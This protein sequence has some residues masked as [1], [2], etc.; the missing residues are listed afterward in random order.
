MPILVPNSQ[1]KIRKPGTKVMED[2]LEC[3]D[4]SF[5]N[6]VERCL[7]WDP[8]KRLTPDDAIRHQWILEGL[9]PKVL[10]HH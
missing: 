8:E 7:E 3:Q 5:V 2:V 6:F 10:I 9:P 1:N 4:A